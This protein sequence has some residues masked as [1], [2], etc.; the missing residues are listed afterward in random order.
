MT[1][2]EIVRAATNDPS[3]ALRTIKLGDREFPVLDLEYDDYM[4]F[5]AQVQ[6][7]IEALLGSLPGVKNT[8]LLDSLTPATLITYCAKSL[9]EMARIVCAQSDPTIT[10][11]EVKKLGKT[12]FVLAT[13]VLAQIEQNQIITA[14]KSFF[15]QIAPLLRAAMQR[16]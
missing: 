16:K 10:V 14:V 7:L 3:L 1:Q 11:A 6:P 13:V 9:P 8:G 2:V 15:E 5:I 4:L 12:P